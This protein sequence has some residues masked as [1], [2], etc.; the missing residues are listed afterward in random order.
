MS[1]VLTCATR[2]ASPFNSNVLASISINSA[3]VLLERLV[4]ALSISKPYSSKFTPASSASSF[5]TGI[6]EA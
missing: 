2:T 3:A 5:A 1:T 6:S 4:P